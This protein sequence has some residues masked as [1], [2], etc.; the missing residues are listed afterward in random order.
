[1]EKE[2]FLFYDTSDQFRLWPQ[3]W[4]F[5]VLLIVTDPLV[6]NIQFIHDGHLP[7]WAC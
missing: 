2:E 3:Y 1:M 6:F 7:R 5:V 4:A